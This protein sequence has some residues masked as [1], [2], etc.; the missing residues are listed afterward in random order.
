MGTLQF[1]SPSHIPDE[2]CQFDNSN[3]QT[4]S[5]SGVDSLAWDYLASMPL[6]T[7]VFDCFQ[8]A[9][10]EEGRPGRYMYCYVQWGH[11]ELYLTKNFE[12]SFVHIIITHEKIFSHSWKWWRPGN[13]AILPTIVYEF[14]V[15]QNKVSY[16]HTCLPG[17]KWTQGGKH[18]I[19]HIFSQHQWWQLLILIDHCSCKCYTTDDGV[20]HRH[21]RTD[22]FQTPFSEKQ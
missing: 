5:I 20:M 21:G 10:T 22:I 9:N 1:D 3:H 2:K 17:T 6:L 12:L 8:Y 19:A 4:F 13:K 14:Y 16:A 7:Q 15:R 11:R 18:L